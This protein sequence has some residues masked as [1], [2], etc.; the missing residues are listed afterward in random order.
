M[1]KE[2]AS[3]REQASTTLEEL[4]SSRKE[5]IVTR[6]EIAAYQKEIAA[7]REENAATREEVATSRKEMSATRDEVADMGANSKTVAA[8]KVEVEKK[9]HEDVQ[10]NEP[11]IIDNSEVNEKL[12]NLMATLGEVQRQVESTT[13]KLQQSQTDVNDLKQQ[14]TSLKSTGENQT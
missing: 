12:M 14:V 6:E 11:S 2:V 3:M 7:A 13:A 1:Q 10:K 9:T 8:E 5:M 4:S